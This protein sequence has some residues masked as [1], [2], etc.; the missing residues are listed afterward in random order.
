MTTIEAPTFTGVVG[1]RM[2][3]KEDPALLTGEGKYVDDLVIPGALHMAVIR[4]PYANARIRSIDTTAANVT[5]VNTGAGG[6]PPTPRAFHATAVSYNIY[7]GTAPGGEG[8]VPFANDP[9]DVSLGFTD[10][11]LTNG[12]SYYYRIASVNATGTSAQ[13]MEVTA[14]PGPPLSPNQPFPSSGNGLFRSR[15]GNR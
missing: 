4:S 7:R 15:P 6:V 1:T 14:I 11:G 2:L 13:S 8:N 9:F 3:R 10:T 12:K 5:F